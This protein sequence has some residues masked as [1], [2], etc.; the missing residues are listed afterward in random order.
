M[1]VLG[2]GRHSRGILGPV[3][4][5]WCRKCAK[6]SHG[7]PFQLKFDVFGSNLMVLG[8][9]SSPLWEGVPRRGVFLHRKSTFLQIF[10]ILGPKMGQT[11]VE[12][13]VVGPLWLDP[14]RNSV[15]NPGLEVS[16]SFLATH[17]VK[18]W[19]HFGWIGV[20]GPAC[21]VLGPPWAPRGGPRANLV[22]MSRTK[23]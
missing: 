22:R 23:S 8:V 17:F 4:F 15:Q 19:G 13:E 10:D 5:I 16:K 21:T 12:I 6:R 9:T 7:D 18:I 1:G 11:K 20:P 14:H 2:A 3:R